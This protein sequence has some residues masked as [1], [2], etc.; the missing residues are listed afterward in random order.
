MEFSGSETY[1]A[2]LATAFSLFCNADATKARAESLGHTDVSVLSNEATDDGGWVITSTRTVPL[3]LPGF[4]K[5]VLKPNNESTQ[6]DTW[7]PEVDGRRD[8]TFVIEVKGA[9][10]KVQGTMS[11]TATG[12]GS[13]VQEVHGTLDVK[14]PIIGGKIAAWAVN[15]AQK[16]LDGELAFNKRWLDEHTG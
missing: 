16:S 8:G 7:G 9:P 15:D 5:K 2:D 14:V 1:D 4:A 6:T 10:I 12:D 13:C 3:D 11:L